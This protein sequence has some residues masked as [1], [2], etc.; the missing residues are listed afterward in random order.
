[1]KSF[2]HGKIEIFEKWHGVSENK[3]QSC[4]GLFAPKSEIATW[5]E[6]RLWSMSGV[7]FGG[8]AEAA[9]R[10]NKTDVSSFT[11]HRWHMS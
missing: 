4:H 6:L 3:I 7:D 8:D 5:I 2:H 1:M 9:A 11:L 10:Q